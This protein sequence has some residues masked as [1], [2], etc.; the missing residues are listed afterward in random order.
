[1]STLK[2]RFLPKPSRTPLCFN[3]TNDLTG[4]V[5]K[6]KEMELFDALVV[7]FES[8]KYAKRRYPMIL[9]YNKHLFQISKSSDAADK[10]KEV[11]QFKRFLVANQSLS[12]KKMISPDFKTCKTALTL[13][14]NNFSD[15]PGPEA[16]AFWENILKVEKVLF[17]D[18]KP[19]QMEAPA[20][21]ADGFTGAM[22]A[23][24]NNPIMSD[25]IEQV[26]TMGDLDDISDVNALMN[27]P[28]FQQM[29]NNIKKNLQTG[30]YSIKDLTGPVAD[31]IKGVQ[32]EFDDDTKNTLKAVTD[33]MGA[34]ERNEP[35]D[36]SLFMNMV[37]G[38][39]LDNLG[40][41]TQ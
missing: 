10:A 41:G 33:T 17:P 4:R 14:M 6:Q 11:E 27:K 19:A 30:K 22:A 7:F 26:K 29:V 21:G 3:W 20:R 2:V 9:T 25:V 12:D 32:H 31:V 23:F 38:L 36:M 18:G 16:D 39:K 8:L 5:R 28:G 13:V 35:V 37:S 1:M 40:N 24:Q 15:F 34:V